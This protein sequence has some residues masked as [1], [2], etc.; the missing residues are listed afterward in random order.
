[1]DEKPEIDN[2]TAEIKKKTD[3]MSEDR[4]GDWLH[5]DL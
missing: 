2:K 1:M 4:S 5:M 3:K